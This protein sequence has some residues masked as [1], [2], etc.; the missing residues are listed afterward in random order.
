MAIKWKDSAQHK[1]VIFNGEG[2]TQLI[3]RWNNHAPRLNYTPF[4]NCRREFKNSR[5]LDM[6]WWEHEAMLQRWGRHNLTTLVMGPRSIWSMSPTDPLYATG[7]LTDLW[8]AQDAVDIHYDNDYL[9]P[10]L[11]SNPHYRGFFH[12]YFP[13]HEIFHPLSR[14]LFNLHPRHEAAAQNFRS[15]KFGGFTVGLQIRTQKPLG[16]GLAGP[17]VSHYCALARA[18]QLKRGL[19]DDQ[20]RFFIATDSEEALEAV[21]RALGRERVV[22]TNGGGAMGAKGTQAGNPGT[23]ESAV[24][25]MRLLSLSDA[26]VVTSASS[27]GYVAAAWG[28]VVPI[29]V[30]HRGDKPSMLNPY[31]YIPLDTEPCYWGAHRYFLEKAPGEAIKV[32]KDNPLWMQYAHCQ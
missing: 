25:D 6:R 32:L 27:F 3:P 13:G 14:F 16:P 2:K 21:R 31:F 17:A 19:R 9:V 12:Q 20:V 30:L 24:L 8:A 11:L 28:G 22:S 15:A 7:Y 4:G 10:L 23:E 5:G 18:V 1:A 29:H 26:L